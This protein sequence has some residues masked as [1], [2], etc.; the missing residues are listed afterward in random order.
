M[1]NYLVFGAGAIGSV[2]GGFLA[3]SGAKVSLFARKAHVEAIRNEGLKISGIWGEHQV[4][5]IAAYAD[6]NEVS[7]QHFDV[8]FMGVRAYDLEESLPMITPLVGENT[9]V[10]SLQN[11]LG[12]IEKIA[13]AVGAGKTLGGRVIFGAKK[14]EPGH[15]AVTVYAEEVMLG[16]VAQA[17][18]AE[19][20][21]LF[22]L[23]TELAE[24][25]SKAGVPTKP[26]WEIEKYIWAK[27]LYNSALNPLS[28]I[29]SATYGELAENPHTREIMIDVINEIFTVAKVR[30]VSLFWEKPEGYLEKFFGQE[31]PATVAHRSSMLQAIESGRPVEID[32]LNGAIITFAR[33]SGVPVPVNELLVKLVK[34]K[35]FKNLHKTP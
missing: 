8:I 23:A 20:Q 30:K 33:E 6:I 7:S 28:A 4:R 26:T 1:K 13:K 10:I 2:I 11:G 24:I 31:V 15:V 9:I 27:V 19:R 32:A 18:E 5:N 35:Q 3:Q 16:P 14:V 34:A 17:S 25:L 21:K 12:N 22:N 29:L